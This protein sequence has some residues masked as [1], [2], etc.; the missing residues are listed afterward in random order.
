MK[1]IF[2]V[3]IVLVNQ[4]SDLAAFKLPRKSKDL[5][6]VCGYE[7][8]VVSGFIIGGDEADEHRYPWMAAL[9]NGGRFTC[10]SA[11]ISEEWAITA[12]HCVEGGG[13]SYSILLGSHNIN[14]NEEP[15]RVEAKVS[16][17]TIHEGYNFPHNDIAVLKLKDKVE[18]NDYIRP[19]C[20]PTRK[21]QS[22][23]LF[24]ADVMAIGWGQ[25]DNANGQDA[26]RQVELVTLRE[27][28]QVQYCDD[29]YPSVLCIDT[30]GGSVGVCFG[31]SG[32]PLLHRR[33][34]GQYITVGAA[35]FVTDGSCQGDTPSGYSRVSHNL[36]WISEQ[37][38]IEIED[39]F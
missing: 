31:D 19:L 32:S 25:A 15:N 9:L 39:G 13:S 22:D 8:D 7:N 38:G 26:L 11:L 2:I 6:D 12:A 21:E 30:Q 24:G 16:D 33:S 28:Q 17:Y 14:A 23:P 35:S 27:D 4:L 3:S 36:D 1:L 10:G 5:A 29:D 20:L 34:N 18:F 37:T